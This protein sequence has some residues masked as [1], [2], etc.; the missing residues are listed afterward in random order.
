MEILVVWNICYN[1]I[2]LA[3]LEI[4]NFTSSPDGYGRENERVNLTCTFRPP[5][6]PGTVVIEWY[7]NDKVVK[8]TGASESYI[9]SSFRPED[10]G[11]YSCSVLVMIGDVVLGG[12]RSVEKSVRIAGRYIHTYVVSISALL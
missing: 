1:E 3:E 10:S 8:T 9:I 5:Q 12:V 11:N 2:Y 7:L 4:T 6:E